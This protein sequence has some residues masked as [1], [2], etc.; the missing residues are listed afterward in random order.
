MIRLSNQTLFISSSYS[1]SSIS[2]LKVSAYQH[3][4]VCLVYETLC[5]LYEIFNHGSLVL[6][7][8]PILE[9]AA[10]FIGKHKSFLGG[11][12]HSTHF[13]K[14]HLSCP[15]RQQTGNLLLT[16]FFLY[17]IIYIYWL[18]LSSVLFGIPIS[19]LIGIKE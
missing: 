14:L 6:L 9:C 17:F 10:F 7:Q 16:F 15:R 19:C 18:H 8:N 1:Q 3:V 13:L 4:F 5:F 12:F 2:L 11:Q